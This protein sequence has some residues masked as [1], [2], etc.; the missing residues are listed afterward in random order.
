MMNE[1][2]RL[3]HEGAAWRQW[4]PYLSERAWGTVREDYSADGSAWTY[5]PHDHARSRAYRWSEDGLAGI[6]DEQQRLCF[7]LALWNGRDPILKERLFGLTGPEGNHGEDVKEYY[8]YL[9]AT[10][11]HAYMQLLYKYPQAAFPYADLVETNRQRGKDQPEYE[12]LDTGIFAGNRYFDVFVEYAKAAPDDILIRI[13]VANRGPDPA[14]VQLLP[15][16]WFRNTW[17][18]GYDARRPTLSG[19]PA[20]ATIQAAH[21]SLGD[22]TLACERGPA[23]I[24]PTLLFTENE[25]NYQRLFAAPNATPYTKDAFHTYIV[26]GTMAAIN[27][28]LRG[29]KAAAQ[30]QLTVGAGE[31]ATVRLRLFRTNDE[32]RTTNDGNGQESFALCP[33]SFAFADFDA[34]FAQRQAEADAFYATLLPPDVD[35][36]L[37]RV[38]RQ[39]LAG[40]IW[41]KQ[42]YHYRVRHWLDG[43]PATP[44]P[45]PERKHGRNAQWRH[46]DAAYIMSMPDKWEYPWFAAWDLAFHCVPLALIDPA[47]AKGQIDL[48]MREWYQHPN[49]QVPA[50][51]WAFSD[52]NPPVFAWAVWRVYRIEQSYHG[53]SD[54]MFLERAFHKLLLNFTWW[55]NRKDVQGNNIFEGGFLGLD[56][57]GVFDRSAPLPSGGYIEQSDGTSWM[58]MFCL[59]M[60]T[61][62]IELAR[63]D[64]VYEDIASKFF[65]HFLM[66]AD[67]MNNVGDDCVP[68][69]NGEDEF[70]YDMLRLPDGQNIPLKVRSFVGL[71]PLF[72][73]RTIEPDTLAQL[74]NFRAR[75]EWFLAH[76]PDLASLVSHWPEVGVGERRLLSLCRGHRIKCLL[77]R[78][79][80]PAE[81]L[82]DYGL[83]AL[84]RYHAAHPYVL[85]VG[86]TEY[87][88]GYEPGESRSGLFGGNSNWRGPIWLPVNYLLIE[89]LRRFYRYYGDDFKVECP[90][91]SGQLLTLDQVADELARRLLNLFL[92]DEHGRVPVFGDQ[93][94]F[95]HEAHWRDY[96]LFYEYFHGEDGRG[97]GASHQT[98]WTGLIAEL[99][100]QQ[101]GVRH[102]NADKAQSL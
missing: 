35:A 25:T 88:V 75:L 18:W 48:I 16:L 12:L 89:S 15:T 76:R 72:A 22:Y 83:R 64:A 2:D 19:D 61:L 94:T 69:W 57:I 50:Y 74:P 27:P 28:I 59:N 14:D 47:F 7:A 95:Q 6:C 46:L 90:T 36:E 24:L 44:P 37:R 49:G 60:L 78:A 17:S 54:R 98:G 68:L 39:A 67:A 1:H 58:A 5:F 10:P 11:T 38:Q 3:Q 52:V 63:E 102:A 43:D 26:E 93:P 99:I 9:D 45:P 53:R 73:A 86:G 84:S 55:V 42:Y 32:R 8:F 13:R 85:S 56:N 41:S 4:G 79:L 80:D 100:Q 20:N 29:S 23:G 51:E 65:E 77:R 82:G 66:I 92:R 71:I 87:V 62:A 33:A 34:V 91:G 31:E 97:V 96:L 30:Y 40:M 21:W 70:F 81:F 101:Y